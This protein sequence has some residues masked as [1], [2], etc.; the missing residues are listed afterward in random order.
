MADRAAQMMSLGAVLRM[1]AAA[2]YETAEAAR[3]MGWGGEAESFRRTGSLVR[4]LEARGSGMAIVVAVAAREDGTSRV[5]PVCL[6]LIAGG[7]GAGE[8]V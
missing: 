4:D 6:A 1:P 8:P 5:Q 3:R 2:L 7:A